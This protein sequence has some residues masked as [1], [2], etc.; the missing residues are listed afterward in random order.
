MTRLA[1]WA[2]AAAAVALWELLSRTGVISPWAAPPPSRLPGAFWTLVT[3]GELTSATGLT[4]LRTL[5]SFALGS[6]AGLATGIAAGCYQPARQLLSPVLGGLYS[7]PKMALLP[8]ALVL[9]GIGEGS[10]AVP[11]LI[12]C[13]AIT[14][15]HGLDAVNGVRREYIELA[16]S[17]GA[18]RWSLLRTVMIPA[19]LPAVFAGLRLALGMALVMVVSVEMVGQ[20]SGLGGLIWIAGQSLAIEKLF[21]GVLLTAAL[22]AALLGGI[23]QIEARVVPWV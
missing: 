3:T 12:A 11:S 6:L 16:R 19:C 2:W 7:M 17:C 22:G 20:P 5:G 23:R 14:A 15:L 9:F 4:L 13:F 8:M 1:Q 21:V 18:R 10:R